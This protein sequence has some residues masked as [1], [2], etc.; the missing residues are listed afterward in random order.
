M[1]QTPSEGLSKEKW[2]WKDIGVYNLAA[3]L[4]GLA[5]GAIIL[6]ITRDVIVASAA[7]FG[8]TIGLGIAIPTL[9][10]NRMKRIDEKITAL[11]H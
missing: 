11:K 5:T 10:I 3:G 2:N 8:T 4:A 1:T 9:Q 7:G 6:L